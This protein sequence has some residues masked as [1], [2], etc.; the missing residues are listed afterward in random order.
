[1]RQRKQFKNN[2]EMMLLYHG[3]YSEFT[4][5][6]ELRNN[7]W[8]YLRGANTLDCIVRLKRIIIP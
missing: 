2:K 3:L 7:I 5:E 1:M 8:T 4:M 6:T